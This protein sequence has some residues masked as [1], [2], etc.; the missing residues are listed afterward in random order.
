MNP[1]HLRNIMIINKISGKKC[2]GI[3]HIE[4]NL[5]IYYSLSQIDLKLAIM[6]QVIYRNKME[7]VFF[8]TA[9]N[10]TSS[11]NFHSN[12]LVREDSGRCLLIDCGSDIRRQPF[13]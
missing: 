5:Q 3:F 12:A 9:S 8:G 1:K 4:S 10:T 13:A 2:N 7:I 6:V 11:E